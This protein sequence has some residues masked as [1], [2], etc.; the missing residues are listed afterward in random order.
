MI[1]STEQNQVLRSDDGPWHAIEMPTGRQ[2][3]PDWLRGLHIRWNFGVGNEPS[4]ALKVNGDPH[5][6]P[7]QRWTTDRQGLYIAEHQ[8]GRALAHYHKGRVSLRAAWR[9]LD[10]D[11]EP[12]THEWRVMGED[13]TLADAQAAGEAHLAVVR[14]LKPCPTSMSV[15][16]LAGRQSPVK[17]ADH[18][19]CYCEA[20]MIDVTEESSGYGGRHIEI[21]MDTGQQLILRGPWHG[22]PPPGYAEVTTVDEKQRG[23]PRSRWTRGNRWYQ[24]GGCFGLYVSDDLLIRAI[25]HYAP[26]VRLACLPENYGNRI[27]PYLPQWG[28][29]KRDIYDLERQ[30]A[31]RKEPAGEFWRAYWDSRGTYCGNLRVPTFG[32]QDGVTDR[33]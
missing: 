14:A 1:P 33:P 16:K 27:Q 21:T 20:R 18:S 10:A 24:M 2:Q 13:T 8:D 30:R 5:N 26:H 3:L 19:T 7:D 4:I 15:V 29:L 6:W 28:G 22:G 17:Y 31:I 12:F 32:F 23:S 9:V 25:A 11:G